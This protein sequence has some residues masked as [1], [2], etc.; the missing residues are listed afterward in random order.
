MKNIFTIP[1]RVTRHG[2][3]R[4]QSG[5]ANPLPPRF[6]HHLLLDVSSHRSSGGASSRVGGSPDGPRKLR[7]PLETEGSPETWEVEEVEVVGHG[8]VLQYWLV[9]LVTVVVITKLIRGE[10]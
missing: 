3:P 10:L 4:H 7:L 8:L 9:A 1:Q 2:N 6:H 5:G